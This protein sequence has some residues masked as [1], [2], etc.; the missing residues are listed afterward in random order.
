MA[1]EM[2]E[3]KKQIIEN[4]V[5]EEGFS[6]SREDIL[7]S[8]DLPM[9]RVDV[10][11]WGGFVYVRTMTGRERDNFETSIS[12]GKGKKTNMNDFR[13]RF[14]VEIICDEDG[15]RIFNR[16]DIEALT[17]KSGRALDRV[18]DSGK[19]LNRI[20]EDEQKELVENFDT[21]PEDDSGSD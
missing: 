13:A 19:K 10:P 17:T 11:E 5:P 7:N 8:Q 4:D 21:T 1:C 12:G 3:D 18:F 9:E 16:S 14:A 15:E 2:K 20:G 6:L